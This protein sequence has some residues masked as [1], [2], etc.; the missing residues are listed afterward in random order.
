MLAGKILL[1]IK[2]GLEHRYLP[3]ALAMV[4]IIIMLPSLKAG[5][6]MDDFIQRT[7]LVKPS[8]LPEQLYETGHVPDNPGTLSAALF[9]LFGFNRSSRKIEQYKN[10]VQLVV[11]IKEQK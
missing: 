10:S 9:D 4:A 7:A 5:L 1:L 2:K 11:G 6:L 3:V 8:Q